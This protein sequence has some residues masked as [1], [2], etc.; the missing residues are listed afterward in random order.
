MDDT[1][2]RAQ[3]FIWANARLL[4]RQLFAY[5]FAG[6]E[7]E[8]VL[9]ALRAYQNA[10]GG[11]GNALEPDKRDPHSQPV[12]V[13]VALETLDDLDAFDAA[14]VARVCDFLQTIT[15]PEGGVPFAL[16]TVNAYPRAPWW[17]ADEHPP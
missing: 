13:Q 15:T 14:I 3:D 2:Q 11:F 7:R 1:V 17:Q 10:D 16:P 8:P 4:E 9:A 12:D 6:G 5:R